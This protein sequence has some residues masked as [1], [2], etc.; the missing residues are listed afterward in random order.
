MKT[1]VNLWDFEDAFRAHDRQNSY[2]YEGK[3]ALFE[4]LEQYEEDCNT[5]IE[6]DIIAICCEYTEYESIQEYNAT[7]DTEHES[8]D[9]ID[10]TTVIN[11]DDECFIIQDW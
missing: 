8:M 4:Y 6:L 2:T 9:D 1:T 5:E 10:E 7:Y 11:I 3:K